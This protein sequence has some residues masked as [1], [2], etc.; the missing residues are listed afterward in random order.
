MAKKCRAD[1]LFPNKYRQFLC[2]NRLVEE[3]VGRACGRKKNYGQIAVVGG[4]GKLV[5]G[6]AVAQNFAY[7]CVF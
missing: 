2:P 3:C 6:G 5:R 4:G 1:R 7:V